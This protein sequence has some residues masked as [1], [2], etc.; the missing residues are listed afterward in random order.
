M[1]KKPLNTATRKELRKY[2]RKGREASSW[3][4]PKS[5]TYEDRVTSRGN[6]T[7]GKALIS[8]PTRKEV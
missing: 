8:R 7:G 5:F 4:L 6:H 2:S 1:E 3:G